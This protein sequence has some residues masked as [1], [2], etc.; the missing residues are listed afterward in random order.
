MNNKHWKILSLS[1]LK[2]GLSKNYLKLLKN[3]SQ[4]QLLEHQAPCDQPPLTR[5]RRF[6]NAIKVI[7][8]QN[9]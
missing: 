7:S 1:T 4:R 5:R 9:L 2:G 8:A 3:L 6:V